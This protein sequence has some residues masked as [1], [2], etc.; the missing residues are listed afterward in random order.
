MDL[1]CEW[2]K[3]LQKLF[4]VHFK[5]HFKMNLL[6]Q[7]QC[8]LLES[9]DDF[10]DEIGDRFDTSLFAFGHYRAPFTM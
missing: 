6:K 4:V 9:R 5:V 8:L 2:K 1:A 3:A 7:K 10:F